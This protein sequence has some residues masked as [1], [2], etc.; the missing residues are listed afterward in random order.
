[1]LNVS[2]FVA[3]GLVRGLTAFGVCCTGKSFVSVVALFTKRVLSLNFDPLRLTQA[4][5]V[6]LS[7]KYSK[8]A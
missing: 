2:K 3:I 7:S 4:R 1:M 5:S 8:K 6:I